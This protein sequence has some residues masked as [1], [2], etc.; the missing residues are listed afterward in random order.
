[1]VKKMMCL[2]WLFCLFGVT[3]CTKGYGIKNNE[4]TRSD[5]EEWKN[6][7]ILNSIEEIQET[8]QEDEE[9]IEEEKIAEVIEELENEVKVTTEELSVEEKCQKE[10][11][12]K[13]IGDYIAFG[14]YVPDGNE[15]IT[16]IVLNKEGNNRFML[17]SNQCLDS[18]PYHDERVEITWESCKLREWLNNDFLQAAFNAEEQA[19]ILTTTVPNC[20]GGADTEDKVFILSEKEALELFADDEERVTDA[21]LYAESCGIYVN[22]GLLSDKGIGKVDWW[23]RGGAE[24]PNIDMTEWVSVYGETRWNMPVDEEGIGVR[25]VIWVEIPG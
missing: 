3:G 9:D 13:E 18:I 19:M 2:L 1:M 15:F 11:A 4:S 23:L 17:I 25:P 8:T 22:Q 21:T 10:F 5:V 12:G 16:W 24:E 14:N 20:D 6:T 7:S